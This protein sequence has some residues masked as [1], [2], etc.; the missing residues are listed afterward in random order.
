MANVAPTVIVACTEPE[1]LR[2]RPLVTAAYAEARARRWPFL[3]DVL[4]RSLRGVNDEDAAVAAAA[5]HA[6]VKYDRLLGF[7]VH[8]EAADDRFDALFALSAGGERASEVA[9]RLEAIGSVEERLGTAY[10]LPDWMVERIGRELGPAALEPAL[11]RM[12]AVP[13]RAARINTLRTTRDE[14]IGAL[15]GE[16]LT[17]RPTA[18]ASAGVVL[19]GRWSPFRTA[20]FT[21]GDFELQDE[22]SQLVADLVAPPPRSRVIDA[23]AGAGGKTLALAAALANKGSVVALDASEDKLRELRRR[24][25]RAGA[26]NVRAFAVDLL[27]PGAL[28]AWAHDAGGPAARVLLDAPCSGLGAI[29]RNPEARWRLRPEDL[30]RLAETQRQLAAAAASLVAPHG[31]L[32]YATC[33]F[34]PSEGEAAVARF[35]R[36]QPGFVAVTARDV[37]GRARSEP[38]ASPGG[39]HLQTWR[40]GGTDGAD[41][42]GMDGFFASVVRR[43]VPRAAATPP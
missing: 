6:L 8:G 1:A 16:G 35:L 20:A 18:H 28:A 38:I 15:T 9:Q 24:A 43:V 7:V 22:A 25:K 2:V 40:F 31:R 14:A 29:R 13:P 3:S 30:D 41:G 42:D 37:L 39:E 19:D 12:N 4:A 17:A 10:S 27:D 11:A 21:R 34:L 23:C 36:D 5:V 32:I 26:D 33:S